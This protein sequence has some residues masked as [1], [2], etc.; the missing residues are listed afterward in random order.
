MAERKRDL[1]LEESGRASN[2]IENQ[3]P[4]TSPR[5]EKLTLFMVLAFSLAGCGAQRYARSFTYK[6]H[7]TPD[8]DQYS[9]LHTMPDG[10]LLTVT[11]RF[12]QPKQIWNLLRIQAWDTSQPRE[13]RL[14]IDVGPNNEL[15]GSPLETDRY[16]RNDQLFMDPG[17]N[18]LVVRLSQD[19]ADWDLPPYNSSPPRAVLNII[20]LHGF[21]LLRRVVITDPLLA[22]GDMGFSPTGTFMVSGLQQRSTTTTG[23]TVTHTLRYSVETLTVPGLQPEAVCS[24][25]LVIRSFHAQ[26]PPRPEESRR[27]FKEYQDENEREEKQKEAAEKVCGPKLAPL[28]FSSL[29]D[30]RSHF[31]FMG[32]IGYYVDHTE[33]VPPQSPWGCR[34]EDLSKDLKY[35]VFDCDEGRAVVF[36]RYRAFRVFRL[37][38]GKQVMELKVPHSMF[39]DGS[40]PLFSGVLATSRGITYLVLLR[41]GV[42]LAG[43]HVP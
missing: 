33:R 36:G 35:A 19:A 10:A 41:D 9:T 16:D 43:Y 11:K 15:F 30:V 21:K 40:H 28:G 4:K 7:K 31:N 39:G 20:D 13:D 25:S 34:F 17:G 23:G 24:Y 29:E 32:I 42:E 2:K 1:L 6:L 27:I 26:T 12:N 14:D 8:D 38:D 5:L 37:E 22:G 18:D 3:L